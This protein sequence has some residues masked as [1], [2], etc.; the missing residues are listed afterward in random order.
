MGTDLIAVIEVTQNL[1]FESLELGNTRCCTDGHLFIPRNP[2]LQHALG[3]P[4]LLELLPPPLIPPRGFPTNMSHETV[5]RNCCIIS[6]DGV[7]DVQSRISEPRIDVLNRARFEELRPHHGT[8]PITSISKVEYEYGNEKSSVH[9][10]ED[11]QIVMG[12]GTLCPSWLY[13]HEIEACVKHCGLDIG[14][15]N[16]DDSY[17]HFGSVVSWMKC[18]EQIYGENAVRFIFWFE[19]VPNEIIGIN[20]DHPP[21]LISKPKPD[22]Q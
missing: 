7:K 18:L 11:E 19:Q 10:K 6:E 13:R 9:L 22:D 16:S 5:I 15:D 12:L 14:I 1:D 8:S 2:Y 21:K 4:K 20:D 3:L 17:A